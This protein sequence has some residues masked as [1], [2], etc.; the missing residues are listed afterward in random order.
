MAAEEHDSARTLAARL[1]GWQE[2]VRKLSRRSIA[3]YGSRMA[4]L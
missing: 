3:N 1:G 2:A 4:D